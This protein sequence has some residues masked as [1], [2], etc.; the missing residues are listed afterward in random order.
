MK[1]IKNNL[2][3]I[4]YFIS[5]GLSFAIDLL[6][7]TIFEIFFKNIKYHIYISTALARII[8]S[9][10]NYLLNRNIVFDKKDGNIDKKSLTGY[11]LLVVIQLFVSATL[12]SILC[13]IIDINSTLV[14]I[15]V[16]VAI[17][18]VNYFIQKKIIF[19]KS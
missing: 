13:S 18:I 1:I 14:K 11:Y 7:F 17:F 16:D 2:T 4:K 5:A 12:V 10:F 3:F 6:F 19:K 9:F 8:S 15:P